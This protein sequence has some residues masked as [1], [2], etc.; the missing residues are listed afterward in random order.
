VV[1]VVAPPTVVV[2]E[3]VVASRSPSTLEL[4]GMV[5]RVERV[6]ELPIG[7]ASTPPIPR[8]G[9]VGGGYPPST[10]VVVAATV[11]VVATVVEG[12]GSSTTGVRASAPTPNTARIA[13]VPTPMVTSLA[14]SPWLGSPSNPDMSTSMVG[15]SLVTMMA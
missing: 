13:A 15:C 8:V 7:V 14:S 12:V 10:M 3:L 9:S 1:G 11:V 6:G 4:V 5:V 2:G